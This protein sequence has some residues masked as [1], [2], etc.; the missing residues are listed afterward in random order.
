MCVATGLARGS[1]GNGVDRRMVDRRRRTT[2][3][4]FVAEASNDVDALD[5]GEGVA[6]APADCA[7]PIVHT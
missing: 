6:E 2:G 3:V 7:W 1:G 4:R 5:M